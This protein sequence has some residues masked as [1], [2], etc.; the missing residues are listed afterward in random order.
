ML[1]SEWADE[2]SLA[3]KGKKYPI[4]LYNFS[5]IGKNWRCIKNASH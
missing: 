1:I 4:T 5:F 2:I 3:L